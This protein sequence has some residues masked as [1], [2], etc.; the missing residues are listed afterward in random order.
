MIPNLTVMAPSSQDELQRMLRTALD[1]DGPVAIRYPRGMAAPFVAAAE[2]EP[3]AVGEA[4]VLEEGRDVAL[5][6][7]GTG[8]GIA[9]EAAAL[10]R[11]QVGDVEHAVVRGA[12]V[13]DEAGAVHGEDDVQPL[14]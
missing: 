8:V 4:R 3:L 14:Q 7:I 9:R 10:L 5:I 6:G 11:A 12:V 1:I 2:L 13:A